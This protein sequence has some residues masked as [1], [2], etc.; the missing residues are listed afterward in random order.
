MKKVFKFYSDPGHGWL[1]VEKNLLVKMGIADKI[2][3]YS[4]MKGETAYLEEDC[5]AAIFI[6]EYKRLGNEFRHISVYHEKTP[7]RSYPRYYHNA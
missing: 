7:I 4:Y 1:A 6:K 2:S 3:E 5:D